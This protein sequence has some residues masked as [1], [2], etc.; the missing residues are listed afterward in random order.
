MS[1]TADDVLDRFAA[2]R[3]WQRHD[4]RA[5]HKPLLAL[6]ALAR[7]IRGEP[8]FVRFADAAPALRGLLEA[9]G[10]P[11]DRHP[12]PQYPFWR[13]QSDDVWTIPQADAVRAEGLTASGD[14]R[15]PALT[16]LASG[17]FS[18]DVQAT[19]EADPVLAFDLVDQLIAAHFPPTYREDILDAIGLTPGPDLLTHLAQRDLRRLVTRL[20]RPRDAA[21]RARLLDAWQ[22]R[23]AAC[24]FDAHLDGR[25]LGLEGAHIQWH[26]AG[27]PDDLDNGLLLC[28]LH[29]RA[30]DR[31]ALGLHPDLRF[32]VSPALRGDGQATQAL[33]ALDGAPLQPPST[34]A[35][36]AE[37]FVRWHDRQVFRA[38]A[39]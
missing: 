32:K 26:A 22:A 34:A 19:L 35:V 31:G 18:D 12:R 15:V 5:P 29:H 27:G 39:G 2:L 10:P 30:F 24:G 25:P 14:P 33:R 36:P 4:E 1:L 17:G 11:R 38:Q 13:L 16:R 7:L 6:Y 3:T 20:E 9:F 23:C 8:Q 21:F 28:A 37:A